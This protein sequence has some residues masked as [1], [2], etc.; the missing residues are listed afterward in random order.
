MRRPGPET[1][2]PRA[3]LRSVVGT[4]LAVVLVAVAFAIA[5]G[6]GFELF[7]RRR[8]VGPRVPRRPRA[9]A[10]ANAI[11]RWS[12]ASVDGVRRVLAM[13]DDPD[14]LI[15]E[16]VARTLGVNLVVTDI[17][18]ATPRRTA[19]DAAL[20][21]RDSLRAGLVALL[22][23]RAEPVRVEAARA[24]WKAPRT[25]GPAPAAAETLAALLDRARRAEVPERLV[26]VALD[27]AAGVPDPRLEAAAARFAR[28]T[29]DTALARAAR[30]AAAPVAAGR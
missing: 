24:L 12:Y 8:G 15:R 1:P 3:G 19:R 11:R 22:H 21:L 18:R 23:D 26:W 7:A 17:E 9:V 6:I 4:L 20:G 14:P 29:D 10:A 2:P 28:V 30:R 27:A 25:F 16:Q 13:A 5:V